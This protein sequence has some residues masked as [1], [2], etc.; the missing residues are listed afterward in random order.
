M[1]ICN[2]RVYTMF[3]CIQCF[4]LPN[5]CYHLHLYASHNVLI[6]V[7]SCGCMYCWAHVY[8]RSVRL[9]DQASTSNAYI[10][11]AYD[12]SEMTSCRYIYI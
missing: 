12:K 11:A 3:V 6:N 2:I 5:A 10:D 1:Y 8:M 4:I 9:E 7:D